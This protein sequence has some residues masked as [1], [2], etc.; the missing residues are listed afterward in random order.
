[1]KQKFTLNVFAGTKKTTILALIGILFVTSIL[2]IGC[3]KFRSIKQPSE[4]YTNSYFD[5]PIKVER[6]ADPTLDDG[7][8]AMAGSDIGLFGVMVPDGWTVDDNITYTI[9]SKNASLTNTGFLVYNAAHSKTL[10]DSIPAIAGYHWW[11]AITDRLADMTEFDS[12]YFT[13][14]IKTDGKTGSFF[15]R[16]AVGDKNYWDRNPAD[17]FNFGGGLSDPIEIKISSNVGLNP[18]DKANVSL[19]PNPTH[20]VLNVNLSRYKSQVVRMNISD[21]KGSVVMT[22]EILK[23]SNVFDLSSLPKGVYIVELKSGKNISSSKIV[24]K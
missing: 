18:L 15:L 8:W 4:G 14:R 19:Y 17:Q 2:F 21:S 24:V 13:P 20:G 23:S 7:M 1:M 5:V 10:Q 11:G 12:L 6:D 3:Y 16:Y 22:K 9:V